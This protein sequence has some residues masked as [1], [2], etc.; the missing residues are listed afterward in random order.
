MAK[1]DAECFLVS[2]MPRFFIYQKCPSLVI[3]SDLQ[4]MH[5]K[6]VN[7]ANKNANKIVNY[8]NKNAN[9]F[10]QNW[11]DQQFGVLLFSI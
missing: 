6:E 10:A 8:A 1:K 7:Y 2:L 4:K 11:L 9:K 3:S 5:K